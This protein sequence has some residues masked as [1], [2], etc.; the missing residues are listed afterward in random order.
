MKRFV[1]EAVGTYLLVLVG[2]GSVVVNQS[3]E[4]AV[5]LVGIAAAFGLVVTAMIYS[6]GDLSGAH[7]N[8][9]VTVAA[10][11]AKRFPAA[12]VAPYVVAQCLGA[13]A[14]SAT[15]RG[16][17]PDATT[18]G[19]TAPAGPVI[20]ALI[21]EGLLTFLLV[22]VI[23]NVTAPGKSDAALAGVVIGA[24][25]AAGIL[26]GGPVSGGSMNPARS[27]GPALVAGELKHLWVY[28]VGP[29]VGG[30]LAAAVTRALRSE[31]PPA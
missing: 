2:T 22:F 6:I 7:M 8:P 11:L 10:T 23:L 28:A 31:A 16:L 19:Q 17:F 20:Q 21:V 29:L 12:R 5:T 30:V 24:T 13:V 26:V 25:V 9:A 3:S 15:L 4:G 14:A 1:A 18:L 27:L